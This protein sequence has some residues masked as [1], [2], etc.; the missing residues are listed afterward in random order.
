MAGG[1]KEKMDKAEASKILGVSLDANDKDISAAH[2]SLMIANHPDKGGSPFLAEKVNEAKE[3][4]T[5]KQKS[6]VFDKWYNRSVVL[7][8][9]EILII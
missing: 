4:M 1:F 6:S 2:R 3:L 5:G 7:Q 8:L 9:F